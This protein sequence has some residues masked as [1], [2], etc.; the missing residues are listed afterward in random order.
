M[1]KLTKALK[2]YKYEKKKRYNFLFMFVFDQKADKFEKK[3]RN[4]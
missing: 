1:T 4:K 2:Y 3:I